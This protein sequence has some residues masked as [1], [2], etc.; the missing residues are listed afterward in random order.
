MRPLG[1]LPA[2]TVASTSKRSRAQRRAAARETD[3]FAA[4]TP[5]PVLEPPLPPRTFLLQAIAIFVLTF[6]AHSSS[7]GNLYAF[8]DELLILRNVAVQRGIAGL[9]EILTTHMFAGY[10]ESVGGDASSVNLHY[11]PVP[12]STFAIE[13]S[14]FGKTLGDEYRAVLAELQEGSGAV[15]EAETRLN[16]MTHAIE[17]ANREIA[18]ERHLVQL[19]LY[20][21]SMVVLL[22]FLLKY[23]FPE[24]RWAAFIATLLFALHPIHSEVVANL[25]SREEI[26]SLLF[27]L[28]GGIFVFE[29]DRT[30]KPG[31]LV[32][33]MVSLLFAL[34]SKEYAV[35]APFVFA[36]ALMLLRGRTMGAML[37]SVVV[38]LLLPIAVFLVLRQSI[39]GSA[40]PP[41]L[42]SQDLLIDPFLKLRTGEMEGSILATK[43]DIVD[44]YLRLLVFPH[45][46]SSDYSYAAFS[47]QTFASPP[48]WLSLLLYAALIAL[49]IVA[50]RRR[51]ILAL[52]GIVYFGFFFLVQIGATMG[53]RLIYHA[54]LGFALLLGWAIAKLPR[55]AAAVLC[56]AIAIPYGVATFARERMWK[57]NRTL[58]L[59]DVQTMPQSA[60]LNGN[61]GAQIMN[62]ALER[63]RERQR[64]KVS[65]TPAD[66]NFVKG[67]AA[68]SLRYL[69]RAVKVHDQYA[70]AWINIGIAHYYREEWAQAGDA[71][72]KAAAITPD[73][74]SLRQYAANLHMLGM[75]LARSG[76]TA[77]AAEMF[78][79]AAGASPRDVRFKTD[80][81]TAAFLSLRFDEAKTAYEQAYALDPQN[82][83]AAQGVAMATGFERL[84]RAT[85]ERPNDPQA[86]ADLAAQ[87]ERNPHPNFAAA[88]A[89][90]RETSARLRK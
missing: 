66:K 37:K 19:L 15:G 21:G 72:A 57:D 65:L 80:W 44:R 79:R 86:F 20:A 36:A 24:S 6:A 30:R 33:A 34:L 29:W 53:E 5:A 56:A 27:I 31:A 55:P 41:D 75:A 78:G 4:E 3:R 12:V 67:R 69:D 76:D 54:S 32:L 82:R 16:E 83:A 17:A 18:F 68:E 50:W 7:L 77:K 73:H 87:L 45:P 8:D 2:S 46:L 14:L 9:G 81:A 43:I 62:E 25:K 42:A 64:A 13:Q 84:Q 10:F 28:V 70:N 58:F 22:F 40:P 89:R 35:V 38:P 90:A 59:T 39:V 23:V 61:A 26:L 49:T 85:V 47:Y 52:A 1:I 48:V 60:L 63:V 88:A 11:R 71:F 51:H 74:P